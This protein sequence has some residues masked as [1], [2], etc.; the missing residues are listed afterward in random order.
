MGSFQCY[1]LSRVPFIPGGLIVQS[2]PH[3]FKDVD[4]RRADRDHINMMYGTGLIGVI[5]V[6]LAVFGVIA[7][8]KYLM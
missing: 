6:V 4:D 7:C 1:S 2:C 3:R 8:V 5:G